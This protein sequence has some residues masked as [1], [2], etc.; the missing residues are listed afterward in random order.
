MIDKIIEWNL[1]HKAER[2]AIRDNPAILRKLKRD[3]HNCLTLR[4]ESVEVY[5]WVKPEFV[6]TTG[7]ARMYYE[8]EEDIKKGVY[9]EIEKRCTRVGADCY[10]VGPNLVTWSSDPGFGSRCENYVVQFYK[11]GRNIARDLAYEKWKKEGRE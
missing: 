4:G 10:E 7:Y 2:D 11:I 6:S 5:P 8:G 1:K 3:K 9:V